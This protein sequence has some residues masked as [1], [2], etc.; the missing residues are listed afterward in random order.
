MVDSKSYENNLKL[1][2]RVWGE[3]CRTTT[4]S[5][6]YERYARVWRRQHVAR[7]QAFTQGM[8]IVWCG[9]CVAQQRGQTCAKGSIGSGVDSKSYENTVKLFE[10]CDTVWC[11]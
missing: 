10:I 4:P 3:A 2:H 1:Y 5:T 8:I 11:G 9:Q 6:F 7:D